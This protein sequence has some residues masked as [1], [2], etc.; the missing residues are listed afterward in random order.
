MVA[1]MVV[2]PV[3]LRRGGRIAVPAI[4]GVRCVM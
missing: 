3:A 2:R 4:M 1:V